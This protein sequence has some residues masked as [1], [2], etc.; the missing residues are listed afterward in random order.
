[1]RN[2]SVRQ[3]KQQRHHS[4]CAQR[5]KQGASVL[6]TLL[7]ALAEQHP[8]STILSVDGVGMLRGLMKCPTGGSVMPFAQMFCGQRGLWLDDIGEAH[9]AQREG[10]EQGDP[11]MPLLFSLGPAFSVRSGEQTVDCRKLMALFDDCSL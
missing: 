4:M 1:M 7:Q 9:H 10:A 8:D 5:R 11:L 6:H 3:W 2:K